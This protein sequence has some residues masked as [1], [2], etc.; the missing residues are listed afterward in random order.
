M[1]RPA[2]RDIMSA[3]MRRRDTVLDRELV[4]YAL[5][6][7]VV[8]AAIQWAVPKLI[9]ITPAWVTTAITLTF[10]SAF[11]IALAGVLMLYFWGRFDESDKSVGPGL[12]GRFFGP[13]F[14]GSLLNTSEQGAARIAGTGAVLLATLLTIWTTFVRR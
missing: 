2:W 6:L 1:S 10:V 3:A 13:D 11:T 4:L 7:F 8:F 5:V 9:E 12:V 14:K